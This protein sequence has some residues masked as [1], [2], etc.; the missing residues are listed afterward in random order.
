VVLTGLAL[1]IAGGA[2]MVLA[3]TWPLQIA[4]R[5]LA[6]AGGIL[7]NVLMSKMVTDWFAD[8]EIDTAMAVFGNS[9]PFGIALALIVLPLL[10]GTGGR[11]LP[12]W[13][14]E[15][16]LVAALLAMAFLYRAPPQAA[17]SA[18]AQTIWP[19][20]RALWAV[21]AAGVIYGLWNASLV[22][23]IGFGPLMLTERGWTMAAASSTTS[24]VVWLVALSLPAGGLLSDRTGRSSTILVGGLLAFALA[25]ALSSRLEAV[26]A[27]F[28]LLGIVCGLPCGPI[29]GLP[30]RVLAPETRS[31]GMGAFFTVYYSLQLLCPWLIGDLARLTGSAQTAFDAG[32]VFLCIGCL[33]WLLF[34]QLANDSG[35]EQPVLS[36]ASGR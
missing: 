20:R 36:T 15:A 13:A 32:A 17:P 27:A 22:A 18:P 35:L 30:S 16:Y 21:L 3:S 8:K 19:S 5:L 31:V 34:R 2:M 11:A 26:T 28:I 25:L 6:G 29:M 1:M 7:L 9:A 4:A 10:A 24:L 14:V 12:L 23:V 33:V